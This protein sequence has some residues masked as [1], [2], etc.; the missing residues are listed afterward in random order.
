M[1]ETIYPNIEGKILKENNTYVA[2]RTKTEIQIW[3]LGYEIDDLTS[4]P[5][6]HNSIPLE[7]EDDLFAIFERFEED[8]RCMI[9]EFNESL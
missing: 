4:K 9:A 5:E 1:M 7:N 6:F 3:T 2:I 8:M